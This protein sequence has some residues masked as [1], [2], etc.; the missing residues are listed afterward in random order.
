MGLHGLLQGQLYLFL[1]KLKYI[2]LAY[3]GK[4]P[5]AAIDVETTENML[6][7]LRLPLAVRCGHSFE[8]LWL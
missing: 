7:F 8:P 3:F 1:M 5:S 6:C 2:I 4:H